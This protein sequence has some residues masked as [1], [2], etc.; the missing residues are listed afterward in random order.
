[1]IVKELVGGEVETCTED[2]D[3]SAAARR[4]LNDDLGSLA[5]VKDGALVGII[6]ERDLLQV[7]AG[8]EPANAISVSEVMTPDPDFLTPEVEVEDAAAWMMAAGY[9][10]LPIVD[11]GRLVGMISIKDLLWALTGTGTT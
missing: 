2:L 6:T 11:D 7:V 1:M 3:V 4:M 8:A 10:H 5:V 9:R